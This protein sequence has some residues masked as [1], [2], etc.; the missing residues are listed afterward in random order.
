[1]KG[2]SGVGSGAIWTDLV[3]TTNY[4]L[5]F[6]FEVPAK[7]PW[8]GTR[9]VE[10]TIETAHPLAAELGEALQNN[11]FVFWL[12]ASG[13][14]LSQPSAAVAPSAMDEPSFTMPSGS[15]RFEFDR[16]TLDERATHC[17]LSLLLA[18]H[19]EVPLKRV[20]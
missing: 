5:P 3:L 14:A 12:L 17:L 9:R 2:T 18:A 19:A 13:G 11:V 7:N 20:R 1:M 15:A 4:A 16:W 8:D 10:L 6:S